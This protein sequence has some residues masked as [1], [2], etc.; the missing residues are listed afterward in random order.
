LLVADRDAVAKQ[1]EARFGATAG[2]PSWQDDGELTEKT[3]RLRSTRISPT[4][5]YTFAMED[6]SVWQ[7][8]E[9]ISMRP[10]KAGD[11]V[12]IK[13]GVMGSFRATINGGRPMRVKR[14]N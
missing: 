8:L 5:L 11:E 7:Q 13:A 9:T 10:P 6:G 2:S 4:R 12:K 3:Y 1:R 14:L